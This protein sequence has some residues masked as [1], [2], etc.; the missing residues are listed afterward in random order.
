MLLSHRRRRNAYMNRGFSGERK[1]SWM[2]IVAVLVLLFI[3]YSL[4][5]RVLHWFGVGNPVE[6]SAAVVSIDSGTV[7][8]SIDGASAQRAENGMKIY[9]GDS[10]VSGAGS[11]AVVTAFDGTRVRLDDNTELS[12]S[13]SIRGKEESAL[14]FVLKT[15]R[16]WVETPS[17][18]AFSGTIVRSIAAP[19]FT[20]VL[21]SH[22]QALV[23]ASSL[24]V[25]SG[26][27]LGVS[28]Q[29]RRNNAISIGEG[30]K[31]IV[32][33]PDGLERDLYAYRSPLDVS[34]TSI[35]F[36]IG[37]QSL[38]KSTPVNL[39]G[40][41]PL[42]DVLLITSPAQGA[43]L[44]S[45]VTI[46]GRVGAGVAKVEIDGTNVPVDAATR[47]FTQTM[48][49]PDGTSDLTID[50][51]A[52]DGEGN[53]LADAKRVLKRSSISVYAPPNIESP[54][55]SGETYRTQKEEFV[56]RG[57]APKGATGI[58][59]NDYALQLFDPEKGTWSYLAAV[60][61]GNM[62][63]GKNEFNVYALYGGS[64]GIPDRSQPALI[65][66]LLEEGPV[67]VVPPGTGSSSAAGNASSSVKPQNNAPLTPGVLKV[68]APDTTQ[69]LRGTGTLI[70][71]VTSSK[72]ETLWVND[73]RLQLYKP[74]KT[75]WNY[76]ASPTLKNL[77]EG[78]NEFTVIARNE[79]GEVLDKLVFT[80][81]YQP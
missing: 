16:V 14:T 9:A 28:V 7:N 48:I 32:T 54:A 36:V 13:A 23:G 33:N 5:M 42:G 63:P 40:S 20:Y 18:K 43:E 72:T 78:R 77:K 39:G 11:H 73:Y 60:R 22:T 47:S 34:I 61:L 79:K 70:E 44:G 76:I 1:T 50:I 71:G 74:G 17:V 66:I 55:K 49:P 30:Q 3:A 24:A 52:L 8:V 12:L 67:G 56:I 45:S 10:V 51:Q 19:S 80:I 75:T 6:R 68:S 31:W 57:T 53:V 25:F 37:S 81:E 46:A 38:F 15:G 62:K 69:P 41:Q 35:P 2:R 65:T 21:P 27:G 4:V 64:G 29:S 58:M 59:V 26:D